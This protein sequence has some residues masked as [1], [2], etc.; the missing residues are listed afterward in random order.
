MCD[1]H[2][3]VPTRTSWLYNVLDAI[4]LEVWSVT[5]D[6]IPAVFSA[7]LRRN[8]IDRVL[9]FLDERATWIEIVR[10]GIVLPKR[11]FLAA[12]GRWLS[13]R[14]GLVEDLR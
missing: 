4:L 3:L 8:S 12:L 14:L 9:R 10:I 1:E 5:P 6:A 2:P 13:R 7:L 11:T